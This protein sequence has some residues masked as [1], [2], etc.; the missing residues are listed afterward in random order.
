MKQIQWFI[1]RFRKHWKTSAIG[2]L[3][4]MFTIAFMLGNIT[5][6]QWSAA[7]GTIIGLSAMLMKD[8]DKIVS[9]PDPVKD[10]EL[11]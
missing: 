6:E 10:E 4:G 7:M 11:H 1:K 8:P 2:S 3:I 5:V 9:K